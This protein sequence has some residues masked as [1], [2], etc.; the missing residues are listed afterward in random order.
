MAVKV[1][2]LPKRLAAS[3][4]Y[5]AADYGIVVTNAASDI[6]LSLYG[7]YYYRMYGDYSTIQEIQAAM[8]ARNSLVLVANGANGGNAGAG[9]GTGG[10]PAPATPTP[11]PTPSGVNIGEFYAEYH[12]GYIDVSTIQ[13]E[14]NTYFSLAF[15][16]PFSKKPD[17]FEIT[18]ET[19]DKSKKIVIYTSELTKTGF[20]VSTNYPEALRGILFRAGVFK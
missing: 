16:K 20:K 14:K 12:E 10:T 18:A 13:K 7:Q 1:D 19:T 5:A 6:I 4:V 11:T 17:V 3:T 15:P 8:A 9:S 2:T